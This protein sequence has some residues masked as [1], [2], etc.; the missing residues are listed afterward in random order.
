MCCV[1]EISL[2]HFI[3]LNTEI[4]YV[5]CFYCRVL[6]VCIFCSVGFQEN[7]FTLFGYLLIMKTALIVLLTNDVVCNL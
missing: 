5:E 6:L 1:C 3:E 7:K 2:S 4:F